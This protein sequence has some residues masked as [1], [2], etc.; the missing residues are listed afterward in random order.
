MSDISSGLITYLESKTAVTDIV[1]TGDN[2]RIFPDRI[3]KDPTY[4]LVVVDEFAST[5]DHDLSGA[6]GIYHPRISVDC[7]DQT[8][9]DAQTLAEAVRGVMQGYRGAMG[10]EFVHSCELD[11][12][13]RDQLQQRD[14][15][16]RP[17]D[18]VRL[19]FRLTVTETI[20]S[21]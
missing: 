3:P 11:G 19:S 4:P 8:S 6:S 7:Y 5:H 21:L 13:V 14:A 10:V 20:P 15:S 16:D 17:I 1:G 12:K 18:R 2:A 9:G